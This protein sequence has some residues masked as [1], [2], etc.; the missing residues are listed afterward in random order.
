M[1]EFPLILKFSS[2]HFMPILSPF[3]ATSFCVEIVAMHS[4]IAVHSPSFCILLVVLWRMPKQSS[5]RQ[6]HSWGSAFGYHIQTSSIDME[7]PLKSF[8]ILFC[9]LVRR[10]PN[11]LIYNN[12]L[13]FVTF[14]LLSFSQCFRTS[15]SSIRERRILELSSA[16]TLMLSEWREWR[17]EISRTQMSTSIPV[18]NSLLEINMKTEKQ[19]ASNAPIVSGFYCVQRT[20]A[21]YNSTFQHLI[22]RT[23]WI[24]Y[25]EELK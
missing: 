12:E 5:P 3:G 16:N 25:Y 9:Y 21:H 4:F 23:K 15:I 11:P 2:F 6:R 19:F 24:K 8:S 14:I 10:R 13:F 7:L 17:W 1:A 18:T 22:L 20:F